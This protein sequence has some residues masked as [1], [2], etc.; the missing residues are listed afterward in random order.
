MLYFQEVPSVYGAS[1][2]DQKVTE[3]PSSVTIITAEEIRRCGYR[4]LADILR[5]VRGFYTTYDRNYTY[6]GVRGF[7]RP[8]DYNSRVLLII[9]GHRLNDNIYDSVL[10]G[11]EGVLN[12]DLIDRVEV[13]R[14]PG[15]SLYGSNAFFAVVNIITRRG[16]VLKGFEASAEAGSFDTYKARLTYG[17]RIGQGSD[18]LASVSGFSSKGQDLYFPEYDAPTTNNGVAVDADYDRAHNAF[19]KYGVGD[20]TVTAAYSSRT[21]GIPTGAY[22]TDFNDPGNRTIDGRAYI[23]AAVKKTLGSGTDLTAR[24]FYDRYWY[25]GTYLFYSSLGVANKDKS[26]GQ[27]WGAEAQVVTQPFEG[28]RIIAGVEFQ[29]NFDQDQKNYNEGAPPPE[30]DDRRDSLRTAVYGQGELVLSK[31][32]TMNAGVRYDYYETFGGSTNPRLAIIYTP[33]EKGSLKLLYGRAFRAPNVYEL[34][35]ESPTSLPPMIAN[36]DLEPETITTYE[37]AYEQFVGHSFR[38]TLSGYRYRI[39]NLIDQRDTGTASQFQNIDTV[40]ATGVELSL[41]YSRPSGVVGRISGTAQ[42]T[43]DR[44]T[45]Q[46][47]SNSPERL[48]KLNII[49]PVVRHRLFLGIEEQYTSRRKTESGNSTPAFFLTNLTLSGQ[50]LVEGLELSASVYNLFD[51]VYADPVSTDL[52]PLDTVQQDGRNFRVKAT[53]AF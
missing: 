13:I 20:V 41:E 18:M 5:S 28:L 1:K 30:L 25:T 27:W 43:E 12:V 49:V 19:V 46:Q 31:T 53:Y 11:T 7:G 10:A 15:S 51:K 9:D 48:A 8:G 29:D 22:G 50:G 4:T 38:G 52:E 45:S 44:A 3:A 17:N 32:V 23:D 33:V 35:Y 24:L 42:R 6:L 16:R 34:Y 40:N 26:I 47:L 36:P 39:D 14:G 21:K 2:Y 37:I